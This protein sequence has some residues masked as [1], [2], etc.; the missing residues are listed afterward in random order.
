MA[1]LSYTSAISA[2]YISQLNLLASIF[3]A[4]MACRVFRLLRLTDS[5]QLEGYSD[6]YGTTPVTYSSVV[7]SPMV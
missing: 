2:P 6:N 5:R 3:Q 4:I 1:A 7:F